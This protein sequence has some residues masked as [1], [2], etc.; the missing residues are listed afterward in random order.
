MLNISFENKC[1]HNL[2]ILFEA[3]N[4]VPS[5]GDT[6]FF[7]LNLGTGNPEFPDPVSETDTIESTDVVPWKSVLSIGD[8]NL[9]SWV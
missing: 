2:K 1:R 7:L 8:P 5:F 3:M 6:Y 4:G 9:Q